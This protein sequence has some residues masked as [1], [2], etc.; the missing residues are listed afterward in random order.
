M[1]HHNC[2]VN[3]CYSRPVLCCIVKAHL[4]RCSSMGPWQ[5]TFQR[6]SH[7]RDGRALNHEAAPPHSLP[8]MSAERA[9]G[10]RYYHPPLRPLAILDSGTKSSVSRTVELSAQRCCSASQ[11]D[12]DPRRTSRHP[13]PDTDDEVV[14]AGTKRHDAT[15]NRLVSAS[16]V[17]LSPDPRPGACSRLP[18]DT[19][20]LPGPTLLQSK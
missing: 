8:P 16:N 1:P 19:R 12:S 2:T 17:P 11:S 7:L 4:R 14:L 15:R 3:R 10:T 13:F 5:P 6:Y 18:F 9:F 20:T